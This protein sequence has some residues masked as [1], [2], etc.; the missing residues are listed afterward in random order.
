MIDNQKFLICAE[1]L[2]SSCL[3][4]SITSQLTEIC[5]T[6]NRIDLFL[7]VPTC[8]YVLISSS[9]AVK[10]QAAELTV[11]ALLLPSAIS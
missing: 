5:T 4:Q 11:I 8:H 1:E 2:F 3:P 6:V 9:P 7:T 10:H